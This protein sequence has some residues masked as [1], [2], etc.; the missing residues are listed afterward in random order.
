MKVMS[1]EDLKKNLL[2]TEKVIPKEL[3][4]AAK[5]DAE[6]L[7]LKIYEGFDNVSDTPVYGYYLEGSGDVIPN[8]LTTAYEGRYNKKWQKPNITPRAQ[9]DGVTLDIVGRDAQTLEYGLSP[10]TKPDLQWIH[11]YDEGYYGARNKREA[12]NWFEAITKATGNNDPLVSY[13]DIGGRFFAKYSLP[14]MFIRKA[15]KEYEDQVK[16]NSTSVHLSS[17]GLKVMIEKELN[18]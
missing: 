5:E 18:K 16:T 12:G 7:K 9:K 8:Y 11:N 15:C 13:G 3:S 6:Y 2:N 10:I 17:G 14:T 1:L 4:K